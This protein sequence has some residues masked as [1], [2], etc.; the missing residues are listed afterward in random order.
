MLTHAWDLY[1]P[2]DH[3][4][5]A[6]LT[7]HE[8]AGHRPATTRVEHRTRSRV[9]ASL[10]PG[11]VLQP[12]GARGM[13]ARARGMIA[14]GGSR[15]PGIFRAAVSLSSERVPRPPGP[16]P[17]TPGPTPR[18]SR[19][20]SRGPWPGPVPGISGPVPGIPGPAPGSPAGT[21][22]GDE[23]NSGRTKKV[24]GANSGRPRIPSEATPL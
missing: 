19:D 9:L 22:P 21:C 23:Q 14:Q 8:P 2:A 4:G 10:S 13:I 18:G 15:S 16:V 11:S 7:M 3:L 20:R 1:P 6:L 12:P 24:P 5:I 17:A